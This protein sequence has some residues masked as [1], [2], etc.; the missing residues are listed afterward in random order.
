MEVCYY[1]QFKKTIDIT[2][3]ENKI[4]LYD[5]TEAINQYSNR[6]EFIKEYETFDN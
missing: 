2:H 3:N 1:C 6:E 5:N 4:I